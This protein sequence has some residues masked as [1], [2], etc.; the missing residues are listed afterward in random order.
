MQQGVPSLHKDKY[1]CQLYFYPQQSFVACGMSLIAACERA[2]QLVQ[3]SGIAPAVEEEG[4][5]G[6]EIVVCKIWTRLETAGCGFSIW[7]ELHPVPNMD[8][9]LPTS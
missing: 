2:P 9:T 1:K 8:K 6:T 3:G 5:T 4:E 7:R